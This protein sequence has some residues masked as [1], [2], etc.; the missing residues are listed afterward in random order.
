[1]QDPLTQDQIY[2]LKPPK[3]GQEFHWLGSGLALRV[4]AAGARSF[5]LQYRFDDPTDTGRKS[6]SYRY[7][8]GKAR[9]EARGEGWS[10]AEA[11]KEADKWRKLIDR[12][13][14]H[15]LAQRRGRQQS[16]KAA[17][18]AERFK[19]AF[20]EYIEHEAKGRKANATADDV[21]R[22]VL[23]H[24]KAWEGLPVAEIDA[25]EIGKLLRKVRDGS[26]EKKTEPRPYMAN[27]LFAYLNAFFRWCA[28]P[29]VKKVTASPMVGMTR[30][31]DGEEVR[32]RFFKDAEIRAIWKAADAIKGVPGA[33]IKTVLL[34]GKRKGAIAKM[35]WSEI[36]D[37]WTWVP[38]VDR[39]RV[40]KTKRL[41]GVPLPRLAQR[42]L[43]P[44]KPSRDDKDASKFVFP[45]R[46][47]GSH[48][49]PGDDLANKVR[50]A[51]GVDDFFWHALR[52]TLETRAA[53]LGIEP[54]VRDLV[55]D[56]VP[57]RGSGKGYDHWHY[58]P[59]MLAALEAW[60][61][62]VE[63]V[64]SPRGAAVLR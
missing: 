41:H 11:R 62:H 21:K 29:D 58:K 30:P 59:Q 54:H 15:P 48:L 49:Y 46:T 26:K 27:R 3:K 60:A 64:V 1:M 18:E 42:V 6:S 63:K 16:V 13:E 10:L 5:I 53:E 25:G 23:K 32:D 14:S 22:S 57:S 44:L 8:V 47:S 61:D 38:P 39:R 20:E 52:H 17:R 12:G 34:T 31:W 35:M 24:C 2:T 56:H 28:K 37:D 43:A 36:E 4:T 7:T 50:E 40:K 55:L 19:E 45:G 33:F 9:T 51:S